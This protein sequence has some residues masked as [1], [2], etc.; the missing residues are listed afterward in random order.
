MILIPLVSLFKSSMEE[1]RRVFDNEER[2]KEA[3]RGGWLPKDIEEIL[4][5]RGMVRAEQKTYWNEP[6]AVAEAVA[7]FL[8]AIKVAHQQQAKSWKLRASTSLARL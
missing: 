1:G 5:R 8:I 3:L 6:T 7:C 2:K 4:C